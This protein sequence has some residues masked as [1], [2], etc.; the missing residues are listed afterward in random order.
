MYLDRAKINMTNLQPFAN[1]SL[2]QRVTTTGEDADLGKELRSN[3]KKTV[4]PR[5]I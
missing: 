5:T 3:R 4:G 2:E 1:G